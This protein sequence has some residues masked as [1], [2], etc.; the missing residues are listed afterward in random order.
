MAT[1]LVESIKAELDQY[2][3]NNQNVISAGVYAG[4]VQLDKYCKTVSKIKG[5]YPVYHKILT[6]VVQGFKAEWQSLGEM[7]FNAK[8]VQNFRQKVNY[9]ILVDD[10]YNSWLS[11]LKIEGKS[12]DEQP[13]TKVIIEELVAKIVDDLS[14][15]SVSAVYDAANAD[16]QFGASLNGIN[17]VITLGLANTT[18]PFYR[19]PVPAIT[20]ANVVDGFKTFERTIPK[21]VRK[22][23]KYVFCSPDIA[24]MYG[25]A[26]VEK[27]GDHT[28]YNENRMTTTETYK[29]GIVALDGLPDNRLFSFADE[30]MLKLIDV[31][32]N[33]P[34]ITSTQIQDYLLK[35]FMEFH[36]GY[37]FAIN[38]LVFVMDNEGTAVAGL[39]NNV[40]NAKYYD[41]EN[42]PTV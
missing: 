24:L 37:D 38:E 34:A 36:L 27:Y 18:H 15:L 13:V 14:D 21:K 29:F 23:V 8:V 40:K 10:I 30:N 11:D 7:Q 33:P 4:D 28:T 19:I 5:K 12:P 3:A 22:K 42:L 25:D 20:T 1:I 6:R 31:F 16:G 17:N 41:S 26:I 39:Q 2:I 32:D 35:L 9:P